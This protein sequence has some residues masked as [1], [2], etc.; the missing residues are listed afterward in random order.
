MLLATTPLDGDDGFEP[1]LE[2][3]RA[4]IE[5]VAADYPGCV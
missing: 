1:W 5:R 2:R 4:T 3:Y